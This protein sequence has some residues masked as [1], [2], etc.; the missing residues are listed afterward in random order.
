MGNYFY[1]NY[2]RSQIQQVMHFAQKI[3]PETEHKLTMEQRQDIAKKRLIYLESKKIKKSTLNKSTSN[4]FPKKI[5][6]D[7]DD[8]YN[9]HQ[10]FIRDLQS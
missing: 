1:S 6:Y 8:E 7:R 5:A 10:Q 2:E 9:S 4:K 3:I